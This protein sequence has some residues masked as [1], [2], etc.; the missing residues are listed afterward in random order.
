MTCHAPTI[1]FTPLVALMFVPI[2]GAED[3]S[4][5]L[6]E[7]PGCYFF[8]GGRNVG[9]DAVY[10]YHHSKPNIDERPLKIGARVIAEAVKECLSS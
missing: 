9:I 6:Q 3:F 2:M 4:L 10:A 7:I 5:V 1:N 8:V